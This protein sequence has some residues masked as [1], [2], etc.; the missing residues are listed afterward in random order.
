M[1]G[2]GTEPTSKGTGGNQ[3]HFPLARHARRAGLITVCTLFLAS[4]VFT[5]PLVMQAARLLHPRGHTSASAPVTPM[6][7]QGTPNDTPPGSASRTGCGQTP[8]IAIGTSANQP[9]V[10]GSHQRSYRLHV[11]T[12]YDANTLTP[13]VLAFHG[14]GSSGQELEAYT[15]LST[16]A[17]TND[18]LVAYPD[19]LPGA[20]G[21]T[22]WGG[23]GANMPAIDD[24]HFVSDLIDQLSSAYCVD[25][26]R[27]YA[28]G[29]SRGGG[30]T[31]LLAC[32]LSD[33]IAAFAPVSGAF[34]SSIESGCAPSRPVPILD[35]H[36]SADDVV[37]YAGGGSE[38]FLAVPT[39]LADWAARDGCATRPK[40]LDAPSGVEEEQWI[41]CSSD[42][43][44]IHYLVLGAGH[45]WPG[46]NSDPQQ[47][48]AARIIWSF[49][50]QYS[51][52]EM[53]I[54]P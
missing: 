50:Q 48:D 51:L 23:V 24:V 37:P 42:S 15:K 20:D 43:T 22:A 25:A 35:F 17:D 38:D 21:T 7:R 14:D 9:V 47:I 54:E 1:D 29:F 8:T 6:A 2:Q 39:W 16:T 4:C 41:S 49:L 52:P 11:P 26:R 13:L 12:G 46:G 36:G 44:V 27:I 45:S 53:R 10:S 33:R 31:A 28:T 40:P 34:F 18:F 19:G 32:T 5:T 3:R 30:M